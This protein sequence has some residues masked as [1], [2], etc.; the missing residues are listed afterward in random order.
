MLSTA[1]LATILPGEAYALLWK[2]VKI[3]RNLLVATSAGRLCYIGTHWIECACYLV[4]IPCTSH[5]WI[6]ITGIRQE[7]LGNITL[8]V[9]WTYNGL[10]KFGDED[11]FENLFAVAEFVQLSIS[12]DLRTPLRTHDVRNYTFCSSAWHSGFGSDN[13]RGVLGNLMIQLT[14]PP[15]PP[16]PP[17]ARP[18]IVIIVCL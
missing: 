1:S 8:F 7:W 2:L 5:M 13:I 12:P 4:G 17:P 3:G 9:S 16:P 15:P 18:C 11:L 10:W 6:M 14:P